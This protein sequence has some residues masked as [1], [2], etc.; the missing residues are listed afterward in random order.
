MD[1]A[2]LGIKITKS[3]ETIKAL[4]DLAEAAK[5]AATAMNELSVA[6]DKVNAET[7]ETE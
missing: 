7:S 1:V 5:D 4:N 2:E 6:I 3:E